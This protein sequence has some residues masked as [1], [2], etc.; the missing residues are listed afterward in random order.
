MNA[1]KEKKLFLSAVLMSSTLDVESVFLTQ[2]KAL[3]TTPPA[4]WECLASPALQLSSHI[5]AP[6]AQTRWA[7][8][9]EAPKFLAVCYSNLCGTVMRSPPHNEEVAQCMQCMLHPHQFS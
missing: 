1:L 6:I 5:G 7:K 2:K 3:S 4:V 8:D 9:R